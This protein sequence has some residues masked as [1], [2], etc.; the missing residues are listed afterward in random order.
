MHKTRHQKPYQGIFL[1]SLIVI[2]LCLLVLLFLYSR[3]H[4]E[5]IYFDIGIAFK[6]KDLAIALSMLALMILP[7]LGTIYFSDVSLTFKKWLTPIACLFVLILFPYDFKFSLWH[8]AN[9]PDGSPV[10]DFH[11]DRAKTI[12][13]VTGY[14]PLWRSKLSYH[15]P[16]DDY[17]EGEDGFRKVSQD[18][19]LWGK[20]R[21]YGL[22]LM[23]RLNSGN[24]HP[25]HAYECLFMSTS[26]I[27][28][29]YFRDRRGEEFAYLPQSSLPSDLCKKI[30]WPITKKE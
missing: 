11:G 5:K 6:A 8:L 18:Y 19:Y 12:Y 21:T 28:G 20:Y 23:G 30:N 14:R 1:Y 9:N 2:I 27:L 22:N 17:A 16:Y 29:F 25:N 4:G 15:Q 10:Y 13:A 26:H 7:F 24:L 3:N